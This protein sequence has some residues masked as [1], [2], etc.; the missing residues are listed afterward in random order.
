[1]LIRF[2]QLVLSSGTLAEVGSP[3]E[4]IQKED[5]IFK[6]MVEESSDRSL[7]EDIARRSAGE[8]VE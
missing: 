2:R 3:F 6:K 5:G 1:L 4:L 7:L 8:R